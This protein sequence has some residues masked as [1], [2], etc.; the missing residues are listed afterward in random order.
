[1]RSSGL[2]NAVIFEVIL[3]MPSE[4]HLARPSTR[5]F[6]EFGAFWEPNG[7]PLGVPGGP[8]I[9]HLGH[10]WTPGETFGT[11][12]GSLSLPKGSRAPKLVPNW[13]QNQ[14][15]GEPPDS[16]LVTCFS[17]LCS[18]PVP[19]SGAKSCWGE[20][21]GSS[22]VVCVQLPFSLAGCRRKLLGRARVAVV[23]QK[24]QSPAG[25]PE[26]GDVFYKQS[27]SDLDMGQGRTRRK[28]TLI[29]VYIYIT[30]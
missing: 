13:V 4:D 8:P 30:L 23:V 18:C 14:A 21:P 12:W 25:R 28:A 9:R 26:E 6:C 24:P 2:Q 15:R 5:L 20:P 19:K 16:S 3:V 22:L 1:M 27:K 7:T 10:L 17:L 29:L 11:T